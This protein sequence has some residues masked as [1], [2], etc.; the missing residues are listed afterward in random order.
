[1]LCDSM[2]DVRVHVHEPIIS[3]ICLFLPLISF[4]F[5]YTGGYRFG[6]KNLHC[7]TDLH[8]QAWERLLN[9]RPQAAVHHCFLLG[10][11]W[12]SGCELVSGNMDFRAFFSGSL[13]MLYIWYE[14]AFCIVFF[15]FPS[16]SFICEHARNWAHKVKL[17]W[18]SSIS[19]QAEKFDLNIEKVRHARI[20][21]WSKCSGVW[22]D[23]NDN[24][25]YLWEERGNVV[26][27]MNFKCANWAHWN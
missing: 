17:I 16:T 26:E 10:T 2:R 18:F 24:C 27:Q 5:Q 15:S 14:Y 19:M 6:E 8:Q 13:I 21:I 11:N 25:V 9:K 20:R 12:K 1:M 22:W 3:R 7:Q 4:V 23:C